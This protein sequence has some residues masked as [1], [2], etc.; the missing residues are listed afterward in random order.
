MAGKRH[1]YLPQFLL[2]GF[3]HRSSGK[4]TYCWVF[5]KGQTGF[6]SNIK[7]VGVQGYFYGKPEVSNLDECITREEAGFAD[8]VQR[9]RGS[10]SVP[11]HMSGEVSRLVVHLALRTKHVR[12]SFSSGVES[13]LGNFTKIANDPE[14]LKKL[15]LNSIRNNPELIFDVLAEE[16]E[17]RGLKDQITPEK[18]TELRHLVQIYAP[19]LAE[20]TA[21]EPNALTEFLKIGQEALPGALETGHIH[22]LEKNISPEER[23]EHL[24]HLSWGLEVF[25]KHSVIIGDVGV[26]VM[27]PEEEAP[28]PFAWSG[29]RIEVVVLPL[30]HS[31]VLIG[32]PI[33]KELSLESEHINRTSATLS[34]EYFASSRSNATNKQLANIIGST[35]LQEMEAGVESATAELHKEWFT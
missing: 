4:D 16:I 22:A 12:S 29:K 25:P 8:L 28:V 9:L 21:F 11:A 26:W 10:C 15:F 7:N 34:L 31:H 35:A 32:K 5:R 19:T 24:S 6:E 20:Q 17:K 30:S 2:S 13:L 1:H 27:R 3:S 14:K 23:M 33:G 18:E